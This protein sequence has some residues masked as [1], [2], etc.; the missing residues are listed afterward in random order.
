M[1][2]FK[3]KERHKQHPLIFFRSP[4][5]H[6]STKQR[7]PN[8]PIYEDGKNLSSDME[9]ASFA[10]R[11]YAATS[12]YLVRR[13]DTKRAYEVIRDAVKDNEDR[14]NAPFSLPELK[15]VLRDAE[16][17]RRSRSAIPTL[18]YKP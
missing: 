18:S 17:P 11:S 15:Q 14:V 10:C 5:G 9:K 12:R 3:T 1:N 8:T 6:F 16:A 4:L 13:E 2:K 7:L